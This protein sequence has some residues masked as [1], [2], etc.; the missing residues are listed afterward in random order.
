ME[1]SHNRYW[2]GN[3]KK[4]RKKENLKSVLNDEENITKQ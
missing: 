3:G 1:I 2:V 4:K